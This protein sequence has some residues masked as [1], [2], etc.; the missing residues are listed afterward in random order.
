MRACVRP[1]FFY[2]PFVWTRDA[3]QPD[4]NT[5]QQEAANM[6]KKKENAK[7]GK[8]MIQLS[9]YAKNDAVIFK[10]FVCAYVYVRNCGMR[11]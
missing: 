2:V 8:N 3:I 6:T 10:C 4:K 9:E 7:N 5:Q 1:L 11:K